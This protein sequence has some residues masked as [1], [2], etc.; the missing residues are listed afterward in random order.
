[1]AKVSYIGLAERGTAEN[2]RILEDV[3]GH[4]AKG[5]PLEEAEIIVSGGRGIGGAEQFSL[6]FDLA[7][8]LG[9]HVGAS[10]AAVDSGWI[11]YE[12]QVGQTG[13]TVHPKVYIA[14]G[15]SGSVQHQAS[16]KDSE[17]IIAVNKDP[18][19]PI[20][21]IATYGIVGDVHEVLPRL[22]KAFRSEKEM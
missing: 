3:I 21:Q 7:R 20:F 19:A 11:A 12:H 6:V 10:R 9:A 4:I 14:C 1:M 13:K 17:V 22:T 16:M 5:M 15:I 18:L 2:Y 8:V